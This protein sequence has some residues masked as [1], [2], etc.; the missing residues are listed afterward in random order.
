MEPLGRL[1]RFNSDHIW[2][3]AMA[4]I[5][6]GNDVGILYGREHYESPSHEKRLRTLLRYGCY[7]LALM[8]VFLAAEIALI[9]ANLL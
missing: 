8:A 1:S 9:C 6:A 4:D 3:M 7:F 5:T 2:G